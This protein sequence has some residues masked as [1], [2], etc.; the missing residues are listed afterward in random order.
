MYA[1]SAARRV[2]PRF[3]KA[4]DVLPCR[5]WYRQAEQAFSDGVDTYGLNAVQSRELREEFLSVL[6]AEARRASR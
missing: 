5:E 2:A 4:F 1:E 3:A 6:L